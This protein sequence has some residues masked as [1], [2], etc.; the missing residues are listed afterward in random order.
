MKKYFRMPLKYSGISGSWQEHTSRGSYGIDFG[1]NN[2][3][4]GQYNTPVYS[5]NDGVVMDIGSNSGSNNAGNYIWIKHEYN[6]SNDLWSR[7][8][9]LK[10]NSIIVKE[11]QTVSRGQQIATMGGT[12][13]YAVHLHLETWI[14]PK[15]WK[16]NWNDR[17]KYSK[18]ATDYLY[19]F[20]DQA[21]A[22]DTKLNKVLGTSKQ[23]KRDA[24]KNQ[25][26]VIGDFLRCRNGAGTNQAILGFIDYGLYDY[27][28][29]KESGG[30]TW[31]KVPS[32]WIAGTKEDTKVYPKEEPKPEP[33]PEPSEDKD[34]KIEE[35]EKEIEKLNSIINEQKSTIEQQN[36][37]IEELTELNSNYANLRVFE[38]NKE[39]YYYIKLKQNEK[40][41]F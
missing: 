34:K 12:Y 30:Y 13:G 29:T 37:K 10:D 7:Y 16:F 41:Y 1:W 35:L 40:V 9:H 17:A 25:I 14:V 38:A 15:G 19:Q 39:D 36:K 18:P 24:S 22:S 23:V 33:T 31:Y 20:D 27:T 26:E 11:G 3:Y 32:G 4:G 5:V 28:E 8:I 2:N 21:N 6:N